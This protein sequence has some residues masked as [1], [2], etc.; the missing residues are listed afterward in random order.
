MLKAPSITIIISSSPAA[1]LLF[2]LSF[3]GLISD[4]SMQI[5]LLCCYGTTY[6]FSVVYLLFLRLYAFF[7]V[8]IFFIF[9]CIH[10][11]FFFIC[12]SHQVIPFLLACTYPWCSYLTLYIVPVLG[13]I[14]PLS[15]QVR[16]FTCYTFLYLWYVYPFSLYSMWSLPV[17]TLVQFLIVY[18]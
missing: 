13:I 8:A 3:I 18:W 6:S 14:C 16:N 2:I 10:L 5:F 1:L 9:L 12:T 11:L 4:F 7:S 15:Y 17:S